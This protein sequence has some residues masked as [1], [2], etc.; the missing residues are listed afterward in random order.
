[1]QAKPTP[2]TIA[3]THACECDVAVGQ[4]K[5]A[6]AGGRKTG[7]TSPLQLLWPKLNLT[8]GCGGARDVIT[9]MECT[10]LRC[11]ETT[12]NAIQFHILNGCLNEYLQHL[13][14]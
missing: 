9:V 12:A 8:D 2:G 11:G 1:M 7:R 10:R 14:L 6:T 13:A 4:L 3:N 5:A